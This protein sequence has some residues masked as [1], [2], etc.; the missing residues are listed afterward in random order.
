MK[1]FEHYEQKT[2]ESLGLSPDGIVTE[3]DVINYLK[4]TLK[5]GTKAEEPETDLKSVEVEK[6]EPKE[7]N[8]GLFNFECLGTENAKTVSANVRVK[9]KEAAKK[10]FSFH[11]PTWQINSVRQV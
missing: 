10:F 4:S 3:T 8:D 6:I 7:A 5:P 11:F 2:K 9:D 1:L